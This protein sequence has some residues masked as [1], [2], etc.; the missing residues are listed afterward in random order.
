MEESLFDRVQ[1]FADDGDTLTIPPPPTGR[2]GAVA[3]RMSALQ[4]IQ[5]R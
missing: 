4:D 5:G 3:D 2:P 1:R